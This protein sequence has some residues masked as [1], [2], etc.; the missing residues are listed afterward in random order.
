[1]ILG[2]SNTHLVRFS[3]HVAFLSFEVKVT[4]FAMFEFYGFIS[5]SLHVHTRAVK[6]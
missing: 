3:V 4:D 1:M 2:L 5:F 6:K